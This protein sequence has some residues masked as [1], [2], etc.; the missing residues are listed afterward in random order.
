MALALLGF[1]RYM[2]QQMSMARGKV[3]ASGWEMQTIS[4][5]ILLLVIV[6][7]VVVMGVDSFRKPGVL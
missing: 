1:I 7:L 2:R 5:G 6:T 4:I 3:W